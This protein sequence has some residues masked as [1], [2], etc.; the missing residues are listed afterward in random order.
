MRAMLIHNPAAG[1]RD[2]DAALRDVGA[3]LRAGGWQLTVRQTAQRGDAT[4]FARDAV[5]ARL[6]VVFV[7]WGDGTINETLNG[8]AHSAVALGVLPAGTANVWAQEI[9][10][11]VPRLLD[12][13]PNPLLT[14]VKQLCAGVVH[15]MDLGQVNDRYFMLYGSVGFD[16]HMRLLRQPYDRLRDRVMGQR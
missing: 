12:P 15:V 11:P 7:A 4:T 14:G 3:H 13:D 2:W 10:L 5:A 16:A 1:Q 8:L 6:D 9:G